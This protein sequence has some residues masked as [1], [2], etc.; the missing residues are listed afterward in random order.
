A[1]IFQEGVETGDG[2]I[3]LGNCFP[4]QLV[5]PLR[6]VGDV[7]IPSVYR[8]G[9]QTDFLAQLDE[10]RVGALV[11]FDHRLRHPL[12]VV[13]VNVQYN[14]QLSEKLRAIAFGEAAIN[15]PGQFPLFS[16][17]RGQEFLKKIGCQHTGSFHA[18]RFT[19]APRRADGG[20]PIGGMTLGLMVAASAAGRS[21][22]AIRSYWAN[23][24]PSQSCNTPRAMMSKPSSSL[25][26]ASLKGIPRW[27]SASNLASRSFTN[28]DSTG[29]VMVPA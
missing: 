17:I 26:M 25:P 5:C 20:S 7:E 21:L 6:V 4:A 14:E 18:L 19:F 22:A 23:N 13:S 27:C 24:V 15:L 28:S 16:G 2:F 12:G 10:V 8:L 1:D 3:A 29:R 11:G 9:E